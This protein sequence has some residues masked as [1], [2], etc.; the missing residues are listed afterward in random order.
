[1]NNKYFFLSFIFSFCILSE[2]VKAQNEASFN[3]D[4]L[5]FLADIYNESW[6]VI[7]GINDYKNMPNLN[8]AVNDAIFKG[9]LRS[10]EEVPVRV[11]TH[12]ILGLRGVLHQ[13]LSED[14]LEA[15]NLAGVDLDVRRL[16]RAK[17]KTNHLNCTK[18]HY[19]CYYLRKIVFL[20]CF[21][22]P[23]AKIFLGVFLWV[24]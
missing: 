6:A 13:N 11:A 4:N 5:H 7:I 1:M 8:Y 15:N 23:Q 16:R 14:F 10:H 12:P 22:P 19:Y 20:G 18:I 17:S 9:F 21:C 24:F 2:T 3:K